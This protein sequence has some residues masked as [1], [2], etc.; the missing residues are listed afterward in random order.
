MSY[1]SEMLKKY[2]MPLKEDVQ[3]VLLKTLFKHNGVVKEFSSDE[4]IVGEI[5]DFFALSEEQRTVSLERIYLKENRVVKSPLWN[6]LLFRC[7]DILAK[8]QFV[9]RPS[10]T[11]TLTN[12]KEWMLTET[13]YD[14]VLNLL[15]LP[16]TQKDILTVK[17]YEIEKIVKEI[18]ATP[19]PQTYNPIETSKKTSFVSR[20]VKLR[21]RSFRI[22]VIE[23]YQCKCAVCGLKLFSPKNLQWEVEAAHIVPHSFNG[24]DD[25][26]NGIALC[27]LHHWAFDAGLFGILDDFSIIGSNKMRELSSDLGRMGSYD[28]MNELLNGNLRLSLPENINNYPHPNS[29]EWHREN[30]FK[31]QV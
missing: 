20:E 7:A 19:L 15:H 25:I 4:N 27:R 24:K 13:G 5:A 18:T 30:I 10:T 23:T 8:N 9:T 16:I 31:E 28:F 17:S 22:A 6:R 21:N 12:R 3:E 11:I 26:W 14:K 1:E 2:N 29:L